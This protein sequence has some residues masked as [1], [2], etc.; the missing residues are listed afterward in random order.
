MKQKIQL[1]DHFTYR[2][3]LRFVIPSIC[4]MVFTS[5]YGIVDGFFISN[6]AGKIPFAA[7]NLIMPYCM[8]LGSPGFMLGTGGSAI[9]AKTMGEG[10]PELAEK[11]FSMLVYATIIA[12][13][14]IAVIGNLTLTAVAKF[15]G[16]SGEILEGQTHSVLYYCE[17]YGHIVI[18]AGPF[19]MLQNVF[20]TFLVTAE[21]PKFGLVV[22]VLAGCTNMVLDFLLVGVLK[23]GVVGAALA[24]GISQAV[25]GLIPLIFFGTRNS[26]KL[27]LVPTGIRMSVIGKSCV[28]GSSELMS[29]ISMSVIG[30]VYNMQL[31]KFAG[32]DGVAAYGVIMYA[33]FIFVA[34]FVGYSIGAAPIAGFQYGADCHE[35]LHNIF[36]KS[37]WVNG[38]FGIFMFVLSVTLAGPLS[39]I[40]VGYDAE[41]LALTTNGFRIY[42]LCT[43]IMGFNIYASSFFTALGNGLISALISFLRTLLFQL[44][45]ILLLPLVLGVNGIWLA[46]DVAEVCSLIVSGCFVITMR[47]KYHY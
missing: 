11:Y 36:H 17:L 20:Q 22:T 15:L 25:G 12:G 18:S 30:M 19:F 42:N 23:G 28:N 38:I 8:I 31:L 39:A 29:N 7:I 26:S 40:F 45:A 27:R 2:R 5:I 6:Y 43:L 46:V 24:T 21:R 14:V 47:K 44:S 4:M 13:V 41:L 1:S 10:K 34:I 9:V 37:L 35:E 3:L 32:E 33:G 16:A